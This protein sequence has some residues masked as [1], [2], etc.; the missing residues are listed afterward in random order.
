MEVVWNL[1]HLYTSKEEWEKSSLILKETIKAL[2]KLIDDDALR[3]EFGENAYNRVKSKFTKENM[4][5]KVY[6]KYKEL[7]L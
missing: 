7:M 3:L 1:N 5:D 6:R 2:Q 4:L